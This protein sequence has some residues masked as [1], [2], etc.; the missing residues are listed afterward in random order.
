MSTEKHQQVL[1]S[2]KESHTVPLCDHHCSVTIYAFKTFDYEE[3]CYIFKDTTHHS[4]VLI[5]M[6]DDKGSDEIEFTR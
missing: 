5:G 1:I 6:E 4:K 2:S 3:N